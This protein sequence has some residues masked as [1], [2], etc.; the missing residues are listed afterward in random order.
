[1]LSRE[2]VL[3][4]ECEIEGVLWKTAVLAPLSRSPAHELADSDVH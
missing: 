1:V 4:V 3:D 2:D